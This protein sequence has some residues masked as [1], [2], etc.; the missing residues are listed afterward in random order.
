MSSEQ[1]DFFRDFGATAVAPLAAPSARPTIDVAALDDDGL[2][3]ALA[4]ADPTDSLA[5]LAADWLRR[6]HCCGASADGTRDT[7]RADRYPS[8]LLP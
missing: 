3:A 1:L 7:V 2:V 4:S 5:L 6:C 8:K